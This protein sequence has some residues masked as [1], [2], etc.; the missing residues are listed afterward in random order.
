VPLCIEEHGLV[1][2]FGLQ[3]LASVLA[4][5]SGL[6]FLACSSWL[7]VPGLQFLACSSGL[8]F[9]FSGSYRLFIAR[10]SCCFC[11]ETMRFAGFRG[12]LG[13]MS[14][15]GT[16]L[17]ESVPQAICVAWLPM[18]TGMDSRLQAAL[19][20]PGLQVIG[21][22][23]PFAVMAVLGRVWPSSGPGPV[24]AKILLLIEPTK[25]TEVREVLSLMPRYAPSV[26][27]WL[28]DPA[29]QPV[30][31][32]LKLDEAVALVMEG[33]SPTGHVLKAAPGALTTKPAGQVAW[34]GPWT[35]EA[36]N[37]ESARTEVRR[38]SP[39][40]VAERERVAVRPNLRLAGQG[41]LRPKPEDD[42]D[43]PGSVSGSV[44]GSVQDAEVD[45]FA[46]ASRDPSRGPAQNKEQT[47]KEYSGKELAGTQQASA[48]PAR[49]STRVLTNEELAMLLDDGPKRP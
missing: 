27:V 49:S 48:A 28:F 30:L 1:A 34:S 31:R 36:P 12:K 3:F 8:L 35:G 2:V 7:A 40:R 37:T 46:A 43:G 23:D 29:G 41:E 9:L 20:R 15:Q 45:R 47:N 11:A 5:F 39:E 17:G 22:D 6:Q 16:N 21:A 13:G 24:P 10:V 14:Q 33:R 26:A 42:T 44:P 19:R 18:G 25:L 38:P 4:C 32:S